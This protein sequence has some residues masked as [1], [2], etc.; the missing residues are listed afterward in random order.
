M[1]VLKMNYLIGGNVT[2][3]RKK[4]TLD[5]RDYLI[6]KFGTGDPLVIPGMLRQNLYQLFAELGFKVGAEVGLFRG[7]NARQMF[8]D[9]PGLKLYGI[10]AYDD[11][12]YSTRHKSVPR[13]DRNRSMM[14]GR[15]KGR[16]ITVI[17]KF[18]EEAVQEIPYDSLDFVYIDG[19]H[20][21]DYVMT[22]I[23]LWSRRVHP[24]GIVSGHD[25]IKPGEY[26]HK[27]DIN[28]K[29]AVDDYVRIH[30]ISPWYLTDRE[31]AVNKSD[32]CPSWFFVKRQT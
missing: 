3:L 16:N 15:M 7:R 31:G 25:Y 5:T 18:S 26:R 11:Q 2:G 4:F 29:E 21:Y 1:M 24:G 20:S 30:K 22:D 8:R 14:E 6:N 17:D 19:D 13:Y 32:K 10:D 27:Y 9:I 12:P 28:V 23:I